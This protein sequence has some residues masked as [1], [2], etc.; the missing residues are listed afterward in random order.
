[1]G[2]IVPGS[3]S[4]EN[5]EIS[6][7]RFADYPSEWKLAE[8]HKDKGIYLYVEYWCTKRYIRLPVD[9]R[10]NTNPSFAGR[11]VN[12]Y[13]YVLETYTMYDKDNKCV[14][15]TSAHS[16]YKRINQVEWVDAL[17]GNYVYTVEQIRPSTRPTFLISLLTRK[18]ELFLCLLQYACERTLRR[19][20]P[21][22]EWICD[23]FK[24]SRAQYKGFNITK[25]RPVYKVGEK[26]IS[27]RVNGCAVG[28]VCGILVTEVEGQEISSF[29]DKI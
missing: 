28:P 13:G 6:L 23:Y 4:Y 20:P 7:E 22:F 14:L 29:I 15:G 25:E 24:V 8:C 12:A 18:D 3:F 1:M 27:L 16:K 21:G 11:P 17:K 26:Y 9:T 19:F 10:G 5:K 2:F